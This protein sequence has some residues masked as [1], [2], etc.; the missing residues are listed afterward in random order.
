MN[1]ASSSALLTV[2]T[3]SFARIQLGDPLP[4]LAQLSLLAHGGHVIARLA[5][6]GQRAAV[7]GRE[8]PV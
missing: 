2:G 6:G 3:F 7:L 5:N 4:A 8:G 1:R